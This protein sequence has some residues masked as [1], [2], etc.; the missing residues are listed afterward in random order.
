MAIAAFQTQVGK[1]VFVPDD[2]YAF[3]A[4]DTHF[5]PQLSVWLYPQPPEATKVAL[6]A[7]PPSSGI[8]PPTSSS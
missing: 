2:C 1:G 7:V 6:F 4:N 3:W 5:D 8:I